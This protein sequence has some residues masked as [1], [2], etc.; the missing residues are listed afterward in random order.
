MLSNYL[1]KLRPHKSK[2]CSNRISVWVYWTYDWICPLDINAHNEQE[3]TDDPAL[4]CSAAG[5]NQSA[6]TIRPRR[7][8]SIRNND[9]YISRWS[10]FVTTDK[11]IMNELKKLEHPLYITAQ[12]RWKA[13]GLFNYNTGIF[14]RSWVEK[15][16][17]CLRRLN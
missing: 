4:L 16:N 12:V 6:L 13:K 2:K 10:N 3:W 11:I 1:Q 15:I 8:I 17:S 7:H 5:L 14:S 9:K